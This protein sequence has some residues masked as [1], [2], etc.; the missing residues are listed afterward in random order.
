MNANDARGR[1]VEPCGE[2]QKR[3]FPATARADEG[4][5]ST[6]LRRERDVLNRRESV[7]GTGS[8]RCEL[9]G[10]LFESDRSV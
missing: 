1:L 4:D 7:F 6:G 2:V 10:N 9:L 8:R 3:G 5:E